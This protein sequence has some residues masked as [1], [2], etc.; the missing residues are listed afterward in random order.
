MHKI[1]VRWRTDPRSPDLQPSAWFTKTKQNKTKNTV[2]NWK[3]KVWSLKYFRM[4]IHH[5]CM[6]QP[7]QEV[8]REI[9]SMETL[10]FF[11]SLKIVLSQSTNKRTLVIRR[12]SCIQLASKPCPFLSAIFYWLY[13]FQLK[14]LKG[15]RITILE[16]SNFRNVGKA[17]CKWYPKTDFQ[18]STGIFLS[19]K[20]GTKTDKEAI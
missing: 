12:F 19:N 13:H 3:E 8:P 9:I 14:S 1:A 6:S 10:I 15:V 16:L 5:F 4:G 11:P 2:S 18:A 17:S 20:A 7:C